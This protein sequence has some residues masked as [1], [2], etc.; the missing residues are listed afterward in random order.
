M[1]WCRPN[2]ID[3]KK[4]NYRPEKKEIYRSEYTPFEMNDV[5]LTSVAKFMPLKNQLF[6]IDVLNELPDQYK[7]ILCGP[8]VKSGI[9]LNL[10]L[11]HI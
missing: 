11:I 5:I 7:L 9:H 2:P 10:S 3:E 1:I 8:L 6:L 4:Y